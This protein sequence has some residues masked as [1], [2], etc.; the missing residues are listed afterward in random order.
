MVWK[1]DKDMT[2]TFVYVT[3]V[4]EFIHQYKNAPDEVAYLRNLHRHLAHIK[5]QVEVFDDD[6]E[7]EFIMLKHQVK[8]FM[9][10]VQH[11]TNCSCEQFAKMLLSFIQD[12]YG[13]DRDIMITVN[14]DNEN[15]CE[16]IYRKES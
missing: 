13:K 8:D 7:I 15:G 1:G 9:F 12:R 5:V 4:M 11:E 10:R 16:V 6:R 14:E 3:D 2:Q